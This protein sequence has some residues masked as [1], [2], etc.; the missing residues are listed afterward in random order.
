MISILIEEIFRTTYML[1]IC[2]NEKFTLE[3][4]AG[5][6]AMHIGF[7]I[8]YCRAVMHG[9]TLCFEPLIFNS[10]GAVSSCVLTKTYPG[11]TKWVC[12]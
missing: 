3:G 6:T 9:D 10:K 8:F 2:C 7:A 11:S 1:V 5:E 4:A 12:L